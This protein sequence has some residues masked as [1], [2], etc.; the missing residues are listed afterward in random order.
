MA[1]KGSQIPLQ[2]CARCLWTTSVPNKCNIASMKNTLRTTS[3]AYQD[4]SKRSCISEDLLS[5]TP[6]TVCEHL[7]TT[8]QR[9]WKLRRQ[10]RRRCLTGTDRVM[11]SLFRSHSESKLLKDRL[12]GATSR[13]NVNPLLERVDNPFYP[14]EQELYW[15]DGKPETLIKDGP[16]HPQ[17]QQLPILEKE[18]QQYFEARRCIGFAGSLRPKSMPIA[19]SLKWSLLYRGM[20][21]LHHLHTQRLHLTLKR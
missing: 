8:F 17:T 7:R 4:A 12:P 2:I 14:W 13:N 10:W 21:Y 19:G 15:R 9:I 6:A 3:P 20:L 16:F 11:V 18:A 1:P 5:I